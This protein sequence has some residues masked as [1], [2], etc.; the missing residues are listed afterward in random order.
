M[1]IS[2]EVANPVRIML[3]FPG[4]DSFILKQDIMERNVDFGHVNHFSDQK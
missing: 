2:T 1:W 4:G 3:M